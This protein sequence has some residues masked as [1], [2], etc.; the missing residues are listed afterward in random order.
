M[1]AIRRSR[2]VAAAVL[3][4]VLAMMPAAPAAAA[5]QPFYQHYE[6]GLAHAERGEWPAALEEFAAAA[7]LEPRPRARI[8][9]YGNRYLFDYDPHFHRARCLIQL[10]RWAEAREQLAESRA[11]GVTGRPKIGLCQ[12]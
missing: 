2:A 1:P 6:Q 8:R 12:G 4:V 11:G 10:G 9:T 3:T 5:A 7:E